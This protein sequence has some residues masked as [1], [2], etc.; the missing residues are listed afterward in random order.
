MKLQP[1]WPLAND[2]QFSNEGGEPTMIHAILFLQ[3]EGHTNQMDLL[4][5]TGMPRRNEYQLRASGRSSRR[6]N[7]MKSEQPVLHF[8][9]QV[10]NNIP[11]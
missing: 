4:V 7:V 1:C 2:A 3:V 5:A 9:H 10:D 8:G 6:E 11:F